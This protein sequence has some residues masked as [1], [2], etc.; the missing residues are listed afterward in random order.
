[1]C[2][3]GEVGRAVARVLD[4]IGRDTELEDSGA[5][6]A[7]EL[8]GGGRV[9]LVGAPRGAEEHAS[10]SGL[11]SFVVFTTREVRDIYR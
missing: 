10:E 5:G 4:G 9:A 7:A 6:G 1:M 3:F 11:P 2:G 8:A